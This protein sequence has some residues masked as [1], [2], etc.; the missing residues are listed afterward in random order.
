MCTAAFNRHAPARFAGPAPMFPAA[1]LRFSITTGWLHLRDSQPQRR[2]W[3]DRQLR[4]GQLNRPIT[5]SIIGAYSNARAG[6]R[7]FLVHPG[8]ASPARRTGAAILP[9]KFAIYVKSDTRKA[10]VRIFDRQ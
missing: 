7:A 9:R 3:V 4:D 6:F 5:L 1:P 2:L 10:C 8:R